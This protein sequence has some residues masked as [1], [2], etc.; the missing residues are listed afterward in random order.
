L[1]V[2]TYEI[3]DSLGVCKSKRRRSKRFLPFQ[4]FAVFNLTKF[5]HIS[6]KNC[7]K[8]CLFYIYHKYFNFNSAYPIFFL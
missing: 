8:F 2:G 5:Q 7:G 1:V 3:F 6:S 4:N